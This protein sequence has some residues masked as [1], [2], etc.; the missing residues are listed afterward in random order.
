MRGIHW[1]LAMSTSIISRRELISKAAMLAF[2]LSVAPFSLVSSRALANESFPENEN[3]TP[4]EISNRFFLIN[5]SYAVGEEFNASDADFISRYANT[6][7]VSTRE[8]KN[9]SQV[10]TYYGQTYGLN[11]TG[12]N[13]GT[14]FMSY[15]IGGECYGYSEGE[16][17]QK[18]S[19]AI[20]V[21]AYGVVG[22]GGVGVI[23][24]DI[25]SNASN[26]ST[27]VQHSMERPYGGYFT[28]WSVGSWIDVVDYAGHTFT[29]CAS[30]S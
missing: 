19:L 21:T 6:S 15:V 18:M 22:T 28:G 27:T 14:G 20:E 30:N 12:W 17:P 3:L 24:H 2:G 5:R 4:E 10:E 26:W 13:N 25:S 23:Y 1:R 29:A 16:T 8:A 9:F 11:G 7:Q